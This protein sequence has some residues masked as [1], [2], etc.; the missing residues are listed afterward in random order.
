M[1]LQEYPFKFYILLVLIICIKFNYLQATTPYISRV[2]IGDQGDG[3]YKNPIIN[4]DYS[5]PDVIRV[6]KDYYMIASSFNCVPGIPILHSKDMVNW[7]LVNHALKKLIPEDL[8][9]TPQQGK[10][11]F[12]PCIR[13]HKGEFFIYWP[14]PD[15]GI[16]MTKTK[17]PLGEWSQSVLVKPGKGLI[18]PTPIWDDNGKVYLA[19]A[20]AKSRA[21][22]NSVITVNEM[23]AEANQIIGADVLVYDGLTKGDLI[24][25]GPKLHKRNGYYYIFAPAGS[26]ETGWQVVLRSKNIYGPYENKIVMR[27]GK[28]DINGPHQGAWVDTP[29]GE[30]WFFHFQDRGIYGRV[31]F[32]EPMKWVNNWP[33]I[34]VDSAYTGCGEPV[35]SFKKPNVGKTYSIETVVESDEFNDDKIGLQWQ[36]PCNPKHFWA[37]PSKLGFIRLTSE[38][39]PHDFVNFWSV[40]NLMLQKS[41]A[42]EFTVT[43]KLEFSPAIVGEKSGLI[44]MGRDYSTLSIVKTETG[45][46]LQQVN[47]ID[48]EKQN[49]EKIISLVE[50]PKKEIYL[51]VQMR[52]KG[53]C[54]FSYSLDGN[55]FNSLNEKFAARQGKWIGVK[56]GLFCINPMQSGLRG[57]TDVDWFRIDK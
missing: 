11:V 54:T 37:Q 13:F 30:S 36:W 39:L 27:Q 51:R 35:H 47:C 10:G 41:P 3:T 44:V 42:D 1:R 5:D 52:N 18:D 26:V 6:G 38:F 8:F 49:P 16:Y 46:A 19:H 56:V 40:P 23:N 45:F 4:A 20:W 50:V 12:A 28:T 57:H 9:T 2:W 53:I 43:T 17:D 22:L 33:V 31:L 48:A 25:E 29:K 34:G 55:E 15:I 14:D 24:I 7:Q 21:G 32:L